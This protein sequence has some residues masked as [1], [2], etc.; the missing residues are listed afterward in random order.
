MAQPDGD[1]MFMEQA[2]HVLAM[3][4]EGTACVMM[5]RT[6]YFAALENPA[7]A[8]QILADPTRCW[9][10]SSTESSRTAYGIRCCLSPE[11]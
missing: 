6:S 9:D 7:L 2:E 8:G 5:P 4:P 1:P 11:V 10:P 3:M